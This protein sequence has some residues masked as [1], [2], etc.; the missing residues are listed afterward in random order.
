MLNI[1]LKLRKHVTASLSAQVRAEGRP[2]ESISRMA[3]ILQN[4]EQVTKKPNT[5]LE[6]KS[7]PRILC[8]RDR[9]QVIDTQR[10]KES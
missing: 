10:I 9:Q 6:S 7:L 2:R 4:N 5:E 3:M 8:R 1:S